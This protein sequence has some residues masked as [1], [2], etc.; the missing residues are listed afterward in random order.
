M[1]KYCE[2]CRTWDKNLF[3]LAIDKILL[4]STPKVVTVEA[5]EAFFHR[6]LVVFFSSNQ[7]LH[8]FCTKNYLLASV[9][10][11]AMMSLVGFN[12]RNFD[13]RMT[14]SVIGHLPLGT[15]I[16][17]IVQFSQV[18]HQIMVDPTFDSIIRTDPPVRSQSTPQR[19]SRGASTPRWILKNHI[20]SEKNSN[21]L[22][23]LC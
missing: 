17:T 9:C 18:P 23:E 13:L 11:D 7:V 16:N 21:S 1:G 4:L 22:S 2:P 5:N 14:P 10:S 12:R 20:K 19:W 15:S 3:C 6:F 8:P